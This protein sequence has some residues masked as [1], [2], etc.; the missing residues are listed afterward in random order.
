MQCLNVREMS[1]EYESAF[2]LPNAYAR[3]YACRRVRLWGVG[4]SPALSARTGWPRRYAALT[5]PDR[6]PIPDRTGTIRYAL[7]AT[8]ACVLLTGLCDG[9]VREMSEKCKD[10]EKALYLSA[11]VVWLGG[12]TRISPTP[13][14]GHPNETINKT[15]HRLYIE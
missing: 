11:I 5:G 9:V 8:R 2:S 13:K 1:R 14:Q 15:I 12:G 7:R 3:V 10:T 4:H 6:I